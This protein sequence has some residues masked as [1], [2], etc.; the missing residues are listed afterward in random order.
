MDIKRKKKEKQIQ[1]LGGLVGVCV[2]VGSLFYFFHT[3][4][5]VYKRQPHR[6]YR[7]SMYM[8]HLPVK[9]VIRKH[10]IMIQQ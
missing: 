1:L 10:L 8:M 7:L 4:K 9:D 6:W 2:A 3:E 5:D